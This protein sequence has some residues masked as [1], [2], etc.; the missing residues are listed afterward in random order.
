MSSQSLDTNHSFMVI[1]LV[2]AAWSHD[3]SL[4][5]EEHLAQRAFR[6]R[7]VP[8]AFHRSSTSIVLSS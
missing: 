2:F 5:L 3:P 1:R 7:C 8:A 6:N 4:V